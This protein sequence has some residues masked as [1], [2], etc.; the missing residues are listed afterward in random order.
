MDIRYKDILDNLYDGVYF[1]DTDR[2]IT[3]WNKAAERITGY[4]AEEVIGSHCSDNILVHV[5][6]RGIQLCL[7]N[8]PL[9]DSI[10]DGAQRE[11]EVFLHHKNG[12]RIPVKVRISPLRDTA[13]N[14]IGAVELFADNSSMLAVRERLK[15]LEYFS[16][17]DPLTRVANRRAIEM[18]LHQQ[19]EEIKRYRFRFGLLFFDIDDFKEVNDHYGHQVGDEVLSMVASTV[20]SNIRPFDICGRWGGEEFICILRN[21]DGCGTVELGNRL[22]MLVERSFISVEDMP[23]SVTISVGATQLSALDTMA[24]AIHR[25]DM[26]LYKSKQQ[27][28]NR[29]VA[30]C[31]AQPT[32]QTAS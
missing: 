23:I 13:G 30:D 20:V 9:A 32:T 11:A 16:L 28:K 17:I 7:S 2:K 4:A 26:L 8:C 22:R 5:D 3:Y 15:E 27:G 25:A 1:V 14:I 6:A 24:T 31:C 29:V 21:I 18:Y 19:L 10:K 12:A